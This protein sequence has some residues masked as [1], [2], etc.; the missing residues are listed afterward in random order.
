MDEEEMNFNSLELIKDICNKNSNYRYE[1]NNKRTI[2]RTIKG[3]PCSFE[4]SEEIRIKPSTVGLI[5]GE[6]YVKDTFIFANSDDL[7][8]N[9]I[10]EFL[11][12]FDIKLKTYLEICTKNTEWMEFL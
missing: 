9:N 7:I 3:S 12:Q 11:S 6:G 10:L 2:I 8:I 4:F 5:N 1:T